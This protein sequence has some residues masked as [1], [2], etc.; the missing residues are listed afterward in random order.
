MDADGATAARGDPGF[1]LGAQIRLGLLA[2]NRFRLRH[3]RKAK[4]SVSPTCQ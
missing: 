2:R 4:P 1:D 3:S